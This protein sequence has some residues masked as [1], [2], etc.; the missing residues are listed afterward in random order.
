[1]IAANK[2]S[3]WLNLRQRFSA[4]PS[5]DELVSPST[6]VTVLQAAII[7]L[8]EIAA[9]ADRGDYGL[10]P[11]GQPTI[12]TREALNKIRLSRVAQATGSK[13]EDFENFL[14]RA[15]TEWFETYIYEGKREAA[16]KLQ[17]AFAEF[18]RSANS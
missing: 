15:L 11:N 13:G 7:D 17:Q 10:S 6:F 12:R 1:M 18:E 8:R 3:P 2:E 16:S 5:V 14:G 4:E 9:G